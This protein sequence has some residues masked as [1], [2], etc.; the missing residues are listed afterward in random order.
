MSKIKD[1]DLGKIGL[2]LIGISTLIASI[3]LT[4]WYYEMTKRNIPYYEESF[5]AYCSQK[6]NGT[7]IIINAISTIYDVVVQN[8]NNETLCYF[9]KINK[10]SSEI[11][12]VNNYNSLYI[13][14]TKNQKKVVECFIY[15][16]AP[17]REPIILPQ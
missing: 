2:L 5:S 10:G 9:Q 11:C 14:S 15:L 7:F 4:S 16:P 3:V 17:P 1:L 12:K 6:G 13:I 8:I